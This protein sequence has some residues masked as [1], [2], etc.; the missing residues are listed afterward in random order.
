LVEYWIYESVVERTLSFPSQPVILDPVDLI[1]RNDVMKNVSFKPTKQKIELDIHTVIKENVEILNKIP[2]PERM[3]KT[4]VEKL[5]ERIVKED[6]EKDPLFQI[7][8]K[9]N[10]YANDFYNKFTLF[11]SRIFD[12][13]KE[14]LKRL[15]NSLF[16]YST[17]FLDSDLPPLVLKN[18]ALS[19][20][21]EMKMVKIIDHRMHHERLEFIGVRNNFVKFDRGCERHNKWISSISETGDQMEDERI[22]LLW[23]LDFQNSESTEQIFKPKFIAKKNLDDEKFYGLLLNLQRSTQKLRKILITEGKENFFSPTPAEN[24][25]LKLFANSAQLILYA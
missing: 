10:E 6:L 16:Y 3:R 19:V 17:L 18:L 2:L 21:T 8:I 12:Y 7:S 4:E 25:T 23:Y 24:P 11:F 9:L 13:H 20:I 1:L 14:V 15:D 22:A 5:I